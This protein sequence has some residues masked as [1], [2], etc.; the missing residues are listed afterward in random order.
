MK[1][2]SKEHSLKIVEVR[3]AGGLAAIREEWEDLLSR[4]GRA[5]IFQTWEWNAA[6]W[7]TFRRGKRLRLLLARSND[8]LVGLAPLYISR[9]LGTP[10]KRLAFVGNGA[11]DYLDLLAADEHEAEVCKTVV[12]HL[13]QMRGYDLADLQQLRPISVLRSQ[14]D[15]S[16]SSNRVANTVSKPQEPCPY[17]ELPSDWEEYTKRLGKKMRS[18]LSYYDRLLSKTFENAETRLA[19]SEELTEAMNALFML[20]QRRWNDLL[21]PGALGGKRTQAFHQAIARRL[22][23]RDRLR[24]H[25]TRI[26]GRTVAALYCFRFRDTYSYYLGGFDPSLGKYSLGTVL[27]AHAIRQAI[28]EGCREFDFLRGD[29]AYKSRWLPEVRVNARLLLPRPRSLRSGAMLRINDLENYV[30]HKAKA[31]AEKRKKK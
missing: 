17:V 23:E 18:N 11:S 5:T 26:D 19:R 22:M 20:H 24:L 29:E 10:L 3:E 7:E 2:H 30:E 6:W 27:T 16:T 9:H 1:D 8:K 4:C 21:L 25:L 14:F 15:D 31:F 13:R 28:A 12:H